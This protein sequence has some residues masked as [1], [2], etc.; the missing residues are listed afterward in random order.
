[1]AV[2]FFDLDKTLISRNSAT[3]WIRYELAER[4]I[5]FGQALRA[6]GWVL[7]YVGLLGRDCPRCGALFFFSLE[8]LLYSL[9]WLASRCAHCDEP[10][11]RERAPRG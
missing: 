2:A 8:R 10:I 1:M 5:T 6:A 4:R 9:P 3:L 11:D 7:R